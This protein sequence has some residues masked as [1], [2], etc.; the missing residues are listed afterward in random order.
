MVGG[1]GNDTFSGGTGTNFISGGIG[2]DTAVFTGN[3]NQYA[4]SSQ[5]AAG[6]TWTRVV[7][8]RGG[9]PD[10]TTLLLREA[11]VNNVEQIQ[12]ADGTFA[13]SGVC[14][15]PGTLIRTPE[16]SAPIETIGAGDLVLTTDGRVAPVR[17]MGRQTVSTRF[18]DPLRVMP[19]RIAAGALGEGLP[20]RDLF[21]S[22]DHA[23]LVDGVLVQAGALVNGRSI[24][25]LTEMPEVFTYWHLEL[26]DHALIL[27]EGVAA[28]TFVD[29]VDRLAFDNWEEHLEAS[30]TLPPVAEMS[31]P[32]VKSA[33]QL[34]AATR[35]R[36]AALA[37][38]VLGEVE[39]RKAG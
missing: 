7:D 4:F 2:T 19:I 12:F 35:A 16:G 15:L 34:P 38:E 14:F 24:T 11:G 25:R 23:L 1:I 33:R 9:S 30:G 29:N 20:L 22:P 10:G 21:V 6:Q 17:W 32:R 5:F 8:L 26:A 31:L 28:E 37:D 27:A 18:A 36:L 13:T 3:F 39:L